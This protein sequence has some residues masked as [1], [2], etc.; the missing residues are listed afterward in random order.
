MKN[1]SLKIASLLSLLTAFVHLIPGQIDLVNPLIKSNLSDQKIGEW[2]GVWHIVTI[3]LFM[4]SYILIKNAFFN[5]Q[6]NFE[7]I[8][9]IGILF[10]L[11][12]IP[13]VISSVYF[14]ILAP[15][16]IVLIPTGILILLTKSK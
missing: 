2:I 3:V 14:N 9:P 7:L 16:F 15:Q 10:I 6:I 12:G 13:F 1:I 5:K 8:K 4:V 11:M